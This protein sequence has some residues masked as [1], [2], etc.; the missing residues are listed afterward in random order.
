MPQP[1]RSRPKLRTDAGYPREP[2]AFGLPHY[3]VAAIPAKGGEEFFRLINEDREPPWSFES[4][5]T[6]QKPPFP[7]GA[8]VLHTG[9][10]VF[11]EQ[12]QALAI[13][14]RYPK[15]VAKVALTD[16]LGF[17]IARTRKLDGHFTL[18]GDPFE[19]EKRAE[20]VYREDEP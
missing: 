5:A 10:S 16:G 20:I 12:D 6:R 13:A 1:T 3:A 4:A 18:W 14:N 15:V 19:L 17:Y 2:G 9:I 7:P 11:R 8:A